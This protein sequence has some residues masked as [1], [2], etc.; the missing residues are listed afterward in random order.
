LVHRSAERHLDCFQIQTGLRPPGQNA[1]DDAGYLA[2]GL[3]LDDFREVFFTALSSSA[4][5][6]S[7]RASQMDPFTSINLSLSARKCL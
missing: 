1:H 3:L 5:I 4:S 2:R 7:G 6:G